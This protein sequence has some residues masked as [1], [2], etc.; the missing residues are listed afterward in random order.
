ML[1]PDQE[2]DGVSMLNARRAAVMTAIMA[3]L[4]LPAAAQAADPVEGATLF[5]TCEACHNLTGPD[6]DRIRA[7]GQVGPNLYGV[8][9][10]PSGGL[11]GYS[12]SPGLRALN[13]SGQIWTEALLADFIT[14]PNIHLRERLGPG[15]TSKKPFALRSG[16]GAADIAAYLA[17]VAR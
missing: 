8:I 1:R 10:R 3:S 7:G 14:N 4:V 6:G 5:R 13:A 15:H 16:A 12:Y 2:R 9:G 17:A 11:E